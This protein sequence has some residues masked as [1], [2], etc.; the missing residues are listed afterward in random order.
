MQ[1]PDIVNGMYELCGA[2]FILLSFFTLL[3]DKKV[4][5]VS[6]LHVAFFTTWGL[7][8]LFYYPQLGQWF[9]FAGGIAI[10]IA[11][12]MWLGTMIYYLRKGKL[13][14]I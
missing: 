14:G 13:K 3:R 4:K 6:W 8:N 1:W 10:V 2:P 7:W 9:S 12:A 5:G 11:N